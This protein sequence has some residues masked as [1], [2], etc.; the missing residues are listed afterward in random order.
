MPTAAK[1]FAALGFALVAF[2]ASELFKPLLPEGT[3]V[4]RL[5]PIN[6]LVGAFCGWL[7]MGRLVGDGYLAASGHAIRT[8]VVMVFYC[9]LIWSGY[10]MLGRSTSLRYDGPV[11]ALAAMMGLI[12]EYSVLMLGDLQVPAVLLVGGLLAACLAEWASERFA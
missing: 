5:S 1:L 9:L 3:P 4:A 8:V 2:V 11:E 10:E 12:A 6:G 7:V